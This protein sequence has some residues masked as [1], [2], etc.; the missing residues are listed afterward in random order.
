MDLLERREIQN[1]QDEANPRCECIRV[2]GIP[3]TRRGG[4]ANREIEPNCNRMQPRHGAE[5]HEVARLPTELCKTNPPRRFGRASVV[6]ADLWR[7]R[8]RVLWKLRRTSF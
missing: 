3:H 7:D 4:Y 5:W 8:L 1:E 2:F 6:P